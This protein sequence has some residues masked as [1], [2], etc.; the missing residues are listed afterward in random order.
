MSFWVIIYPN[1][2]NGYEVTVGC[3]L[4]IVFI[5]LLYEQCNNQP[6]MRASLPKPQESVMDTGRVYYYWNIPVWKVMWH[7]GNFICGKVQL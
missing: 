6:E 3:S 2:F 1:K 7:C 4:L 5:Q